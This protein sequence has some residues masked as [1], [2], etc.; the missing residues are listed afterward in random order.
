MNRSHPNPDMPRNGASL[1]LP[2]FD[3]DQLLHHI[4]QVIGTQKL[5]GSVFLTV[6]LKF[7]KQL[8]I[9][10]L[11]DSKEWLWLVTLGLDKSLPDNS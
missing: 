1:D 8:G 6:Q 9:Q 3:T 11:F 2:H 7:Q 10:L 5:I 4:V